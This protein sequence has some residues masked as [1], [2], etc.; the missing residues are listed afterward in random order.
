MPLAARAWESTVL[1]HFHI[2]SY[3]SCSSFMS[4]NNYCLVSSLPVWYN[5]DFTQPHKNVVKSGDL[6]GH[7]SSYPSSLIICIP[8]P[9]NLL[10]QNVEVLHHVVPTSAILFEEE[11]SVRSS[12]QTS[13]NEMWTI[14]MIANYSICLPKMCW[15]LH[16]TTLCWLSW[17]Q[18]CKCFCTGDTITVKLSLIH[19]QNVIHKLWLSFQPPEQFFTVGMISW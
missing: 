18:E 10:C 9:C 11:I 13:L 12:C 16:C 3:C 4:S 15:K 1:M 8:V 6:T 2:I 19:E 5:L 17:D 14:N 7:A